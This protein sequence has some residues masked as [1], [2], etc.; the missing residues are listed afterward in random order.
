ML[1]YNQPTEVTEIAFNQIM[2]GVR[3]SCAG[4]KTDDGK[5]YVKLWDCSYRK[6][7][8]SIISK[9]PIITTSN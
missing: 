1:K 9:S 5:Y 6:D 3:G 4:Q 7:V 8:E 2:N